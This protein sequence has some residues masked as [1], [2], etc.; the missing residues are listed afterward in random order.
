MDHKT[1]LSSVPAHR[2]VELTRRRDAP[3][4][5][6]FG[7]H[8]GLIAFFAM[9][10]GAGVP[11]WPVLLLPQAI[12]L[13]CLFHLTHE[14]THVTPFR[15][16][17]LN[18]AAGHLCGFLLILPFRWFT[19]FHMAHHKWTN[20]PGKDPEL[21]S[22]KPRTL[23]GW[24]W[25]VCGLPHWGRSIGLLVRLALGK[26]RPIFL[27]ERARADA[28]KEAR[29]MLLGYATAL[30]VLPFAPII[31][32]GWLLPLLIGQ[33]FLRLYLLAEHGDLPHVADMFDNTRTTNTNRLLR[34]LTWNMTYHTE[35]HVWPS[36]PFH[37]LPDL[38]EDMKSVLKHTAPSYSAFTRAYLARRLQDGVA[39]ATPSLKSKETT[40]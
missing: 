14:A 11:M 16:Q 36:V 5:V 25:H 29:L 31:F 10:I 13:T 18:R 19:A 23:K 40:E 12:L 37:K 33:P 24:L 34:W 7:I 39:E 27:G 4:L 35:H 38:H 32:W 20:I 22:P 3:G 2:R 9:L 17:W 1:W 30:L 8:L 21:A 15:T 28:E 6:R 26:E